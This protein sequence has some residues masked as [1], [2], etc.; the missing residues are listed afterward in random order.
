MSMLRKILLLLLVLM[1]VPYFAL[2]Q[3]TTDPSDQFLGKVSE[4]KYRNSFFGFTL[5]PSPE[6]HILS[7]QERAIY[8]KAGVE[9]LSKDVEE[10]RAAFAKAAGQEV[11][12]FSLAMEKPGSTGVSSLNVGGL[13]QPEGATA[14][15][16]CDTAAEYLVRNPKF[17]VASKTTALKRGGRSFARVEFNFVNGEHKLSLRYYATIQKGY[18]ITFVITHLS[19][20]D[21]DAF[22]KVL[23]SL[24]FS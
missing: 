3:P 12:L 8:K 17:T 20:N 23:D 9:M 24:E 1:A 19:K 10:N 14:E 7:D 13:K 4:G 16:V 15:L 2:A 18:S 5:S 21:L 11:L 22:E 6:M